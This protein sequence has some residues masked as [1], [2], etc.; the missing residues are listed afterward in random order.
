MSEFQDALRLAVEGK[1][2]QYLA[3]IKDQPIKSRLDGVRAW[4][5]SPRKTQ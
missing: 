1:E 5:V 2:P 4:I 3:V